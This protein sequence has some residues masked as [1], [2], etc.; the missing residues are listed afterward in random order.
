MNS[1]SIA[2]NQPGSFE[3][4]PHAAH[5]G[6]RRGVGPF[7]GHLAEMIAAM[8]IGMPLFGMPLRALQGALLGAS[9][10]G[11]PELRALG[12]ATAMTVAMVAWMRFRGHSWRASAEM[13]A[14]MVVPTVALFPLLWVGMISGGMLVGLVHVLMVPSMLG[15]MLYRR[16]EYGM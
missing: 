14:A 8:M 2:L 15:V 6:G 10:V 9:S 5:N 16:R 12:M 13:A 3:A 7:L 11:I 1:Q 4:T